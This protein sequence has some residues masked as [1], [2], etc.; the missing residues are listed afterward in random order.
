MVEKK[1]K[2]KKIMVIIYISY[3]FFDICLFPFIY[4]FSLCLK[5]IYIDHFV[6]ISTFIVISNL[7]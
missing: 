2:K 3:L 1:P 7:W 5:K 6:M 4:F